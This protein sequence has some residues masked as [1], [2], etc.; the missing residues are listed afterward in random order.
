[1]VLSPN[2]AS[3]YVL[4]EGVMDSEDSDTPPSFLLV[5]ALDPKS[6]APVLKQTLAAG[7]P[8][9]PGPTNIAVH[10][11]GR[12]VYLSNYYLGNSNNN[13]TGIFSVQGDGTLVYTGLG[14]PIQ[15]QTSYGAVIHP[16]GRF[17][18]TA[19]DGSP[20]GELQSQPCAVF[21]TNVFAM[22]V[23][24]GSG[25]LTAVSGSP[26]ILQQ[27]VCEPGVAPQWLAP[28]IDSSGRRL[29]MIDKGNRTITVF[30]IDPS[31][32]ALTL[33]PGS[34]VDTEN[35]GPAFDAAAID[36]QGRFLYVR[37]PGLSFT[38]FSVS[39]SVAAA[40]SAD[41]PSGAL[42]LL[43]GMPVRVTP[44][45]E[46]SEARRSIAIDSSG[47]L[48]LGNE[49]DFTSDSSGPDTLMEFRID[50][51]TGALTPVSSATVSLAG[52]VSKIVVAKPR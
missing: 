3:A 38:G 7:D 8:N 47:T 20:A 27:K 11:S 37:G 2:G 35:S 42:P 28:Q 16:S 9:G 30:A 18:Y 52:T 15:L 26:F 41:V 40:V 45:P 39:A 34:T 32:G 24:P 13:G 49:G 50:P 23:N 51:A 12:F 33:L 10:P 44:S 29:F 46:F 4:A 5:Y 17:L 19:T 1:M 21:H 31:S 14:G 25:A 6:G 22:R 43:P 48:L 36:P